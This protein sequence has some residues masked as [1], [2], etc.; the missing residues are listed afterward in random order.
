MR[1]ALLL[2]FALRCELT[3]A[4]TLCWYSYTSLHLKP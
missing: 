1:R 4:Q 2:E 3:P